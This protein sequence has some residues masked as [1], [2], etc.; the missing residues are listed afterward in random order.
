MVQ[1]AGYYKV[2]VSEVTRKLRMIFVRLVAECSNSFLIHIMPLAIGAYQ[3]YRDKYNV[4]CRPA[5]EVSGESK[6]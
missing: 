2:I 4:Q 1:P 5:G 3:E 6:R